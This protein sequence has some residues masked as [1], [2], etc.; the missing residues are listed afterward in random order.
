MNIPVT[1][2]LSSQVIETLA[3]LLECGYKLVTFERYARYLAVEKKGFV[4][5]LESSGGKLKMFG[6]VG[7]RMGDG[8]GMLVE[9]RE[10]KIF[11]C[12][13]ESVAATHEL[14]A[15]YERVKA[16]LARLIERGAAKSR[17]Q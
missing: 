16:E 8:I 3:A 12:H 9:R 2:E 14:L 17:K 5:L 6:Q 10:G 13:G 1:P 7:Y 15:A 4:A 11:V